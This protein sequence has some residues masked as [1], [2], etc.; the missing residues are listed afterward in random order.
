MSL[1]LLHVHYFDRTSLPSAER[2]LV[3]TGRKS[4]E[5]EEVGCPDGVISFSWASLEVAASCR[6]SVRPA[7]IH[8]Y[9]R[10]PPPAHPRRLR[11]SRLL[12]ASN[13]PV[14]SPGR[15]PPLAAHKPEGRAVALHHH[16]KWRRCSPSSPVLCHRRLHR[17]KKASLE[18]SGAPCTSLRSHDKEP[19]LG[20]LAPRTLSA[21]HTADP[22]ERIGAA[23]FFSVCD[24]SQRP[25]TY[26]LWYSPLP[27]RRSPSVCSL[28]VRARWELLL[29]LS[30]SACGDS[31]TPLQDPVL[32]SLS[33][34][35]SSLAV[36]KVRRARAQAR[37]QWPRRRSDELDSVRSL[38]FL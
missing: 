37:R 16:H 34:F 7:R 14:S 9:T 1:K 3:R 17:C 36:G 8:F 6:C 12:R 35:P 23:A 13:F 19:S 5:G 20:T 24:G 38:L 32:N 2:R 4:G 22:D 28:A 26:F 21:C 29:R 30:F 33:S 10:P 18:R 11:L 31:T 27:L 25:E 15:K